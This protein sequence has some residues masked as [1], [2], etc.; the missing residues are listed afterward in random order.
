MD[1]DAAVTAGLYEVIGANIDD[2]YIEALKSQ[3][4][5]WDSIREVSKDLKIV[6]TPLHGTGNIPARRVLKE[7]HL[8]RQEPGQ[9]RQDSHRLPPVLRRGQSLRITQS[10]H[11]FPFYCLHAI[12]FLC[13]P[14]CNPFA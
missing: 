3:V 6:Y 13:Q 10:E 14:R 11:Q 9:I 7:L 2:L 5:H 12:Y 4:I 8:L 1:K